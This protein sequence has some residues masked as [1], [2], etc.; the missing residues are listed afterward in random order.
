MKG[1][2]WR[3]PGMPYLI[4]KHT[5]SIKLD[6]PIQFILID[7]KYIQMPVLALF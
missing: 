2:G 6:I 5:T 7:E 4:I 3:I 1:N